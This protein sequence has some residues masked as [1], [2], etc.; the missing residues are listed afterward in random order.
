MVRGRRYCSAYCQWAPASTPLHRLHTSSVPLTGSAYVQH[1]GHLP[2][3]DAR[4]DKPS[5]SRAESASLVRLHAPLTSGG[6]ATPRCM[7]ATMNRRASSAAAT[8]Q[9]KQRV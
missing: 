3:P 5:E 8:E 1:R 7:S 2:L 4:T 9:K 6:G